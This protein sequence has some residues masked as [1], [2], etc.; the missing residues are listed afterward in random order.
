[1]I[2]LKVNL[3]AR[4]FILT[5]FVVLASLEVL[6]VV[7]DIVFNYSK[8]IPIGSIQRLFNIARED[9][10]QA[11]AASVQTLFV[12]MILW[13]IY[14]K[15]RSRAWASIAAF[16]TYLAVDD[17]AKFHERVGTAVKDMNNSGREVAEATISLEHSY[18]W[19]Y[20]FGPFLIS[21]G[22]FILFFMWR[23]LQTK[24]LRLLIFGA[25]ACYGVA[26]GLDFVEGLPGAYDAI[27]ATSGLSPKFVSH[28]GRVIEEFLELFGTTLFLVVFLCHFI[29][30]S[31]KT[32]ITFDKA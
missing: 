26:V 4:K 17:G 28:F 9:S 21:M 25:L 16:F 30:I 31:P 20:V 10:L 6:F 8:L 7:L 27:A 22:L 29:Q 32:V 23:E 24:N 12:G 2:E 14:F 1:M 11:W 15:N 3:N 18:T 5:V 13:L 19:Q